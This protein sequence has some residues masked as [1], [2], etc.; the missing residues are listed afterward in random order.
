M[1]ATSVN[2]TGGKFAA[3]V[4]D[5]QYITLPSPWHRPVPPPH[6]YMYNPLLGVFIIHTVHTN[7]HNYICT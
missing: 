4:V 5:R 3:G 1:F 6:M 2:D 7:N